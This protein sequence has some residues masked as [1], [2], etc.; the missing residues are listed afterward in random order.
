MFESIARLRPMKSGS[1]RLWCCVVLSLAPGGCGCTPMVEGV[2]ANDTLPAA[3]VTERSYLLPV[4][5]SGELNLT[6]ERQDSR[7]GYAGSVY[8]FVTRPECPT[9]TTDPLSMTD[10]QRFQPM[11]LVLANSYKDQNCCQGRITLASPVHMSK[12]EMV[13]VFLYGLYQTRGS[14]LPTDVSGRRRGV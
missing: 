1:W 7:E 13:K 14:P 4:P 10:G 11:C 12:G 5:A 8:L 6:L 2:L 9:L 3:A